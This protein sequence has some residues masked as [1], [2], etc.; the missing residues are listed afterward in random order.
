MIDKRVPCGSSRNSTG[1]RPGVTPDSIR[2]VRFFML[3]AARSSQDCCTTCFFPETG[4]FSK[5]TGRRLSTN[6]QSLR[7]IRDLGNFSKSKY[8]ERKQGEDSLETGR[9]LFP[10]LPGFG[11][12]W[13]RR[14]RHRRRAADRDSA[15]YR[16]CSSSHPRASKHLMRPTIRGMR[17]PAQLSDVVSHPRDGARKTK[18]KTLRRNTLART[19]PQTPLAG[20]ATDAAQAAS[21]LISTA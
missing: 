6:G 10:F 17:G 21:G 14:H 18:K 4:R 1:K 16:V 5:K 15:R 2:A 8:T 20:G 13:I 3:I 9:P 19:V 11:S 12:F 7:G